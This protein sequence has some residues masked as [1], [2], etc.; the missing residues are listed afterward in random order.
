MPRSLPTRWITLLV[1]CALTA[2]GCVGTTD[3]G[4]QSE[5]GSLAVDLVLAGGIEINQVGWQ[6]TGNGMDMSGD[7][8]VSAPGS[9]ASV[10]VFGLPPGEMDYTV[11][12]TA[13]SSDEAVTCEG[14]APFNVEVGQ[15]TNVM[16]MLNCKKPRTLG[17]VRVNGKFNICTELTKA[18]VS[19]LE[20]SVGNDIS[21]SA[22]AFDEEGD[23]ILYIWTGNG[24]SIADPSAAS[25][26]YTCQEVGDHTVTIMVT[27]NDVYCRM[28]TWTI[29]VTCVE[30]DGGD[31]CEDVM[32]EDDGNECTATECNPA[33]GACETSNVADGTECDGG[34]CSGGVCVEVDLCE[35]V[36]CEDDGNECT[37]EA[38]DPAD[39]VCKTS[40]ADNGTDCSGGDGMCVDGACMISDLCEGVVC[41]DTGN[42]CTVAMCNAATG[43]CDTMNVT[44]GTECNGGDGACSGGVCVDNNLCDGVD[45]SSGNECVQDG[46]CDP[47]DGQCIAGDNQPAGTSCND[48]SGDVCDGNG[49]CVECNSADD[50]PDDGNECTAEACTSNACSTSPVVDG[51]MCDDDM[52]VCD[53]GV[54]V[55]ANLCEG[56]DC[57][58]GNECTQDLCDPGTGACSNPPVADGA[59]CMC[60]ICGAEGLCMMGQCVDPCDDIDCSDGNQ[61]TAD[62]CNVGV[63]S[64]PNVGPG[65]ACSQNGGNVCD[66]AGT[67]VECNID[68]QCDV[69]FSETCVDNT[70]VAPASVTC[71]FANNGSD[72][73]PT[74]SIVGVGCTNNVTSAQSPF[75]FTLVVDVPEAVVGGSAFDASFDGIGVFPEFFLDA[76]QAVVP[77]GVDVAELV[78]IVST[79]QVRSG[80]TGPDVALLADL[81]SL[82]PGPTRI[83]NFPFD[84]VCTADGECLGGVCNPPVNL[85]TLPNSTDCS[86]GGVCDTLGKLATQC[87]PNGFCITGD[88]VIEFEESAPISYTAD[89]SGSVLFGWA[90]QGVP[91]LTLCPAAAPNCTDAWMPDGCY[92]LPTAVFANP[93]APIGIRVNASGLFVPIQCAGGTA[94]GICASGEGCI[95]DADCSTAPCTLTT[96]VICPTPDAGLISC[97]IN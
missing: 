67:C 95:V 6:I 35:G 36:T 33:N 20:T 42:E 58:D 2:L 81:G 87:T 92:D 74:S 27:D 39:G 43:I 76:A 86:A 26:T 91:D 54:C 88:L 18:V 49:A 4:P 45:C 57:S 89:A 10:E 46:T 13:T 71:N 52:G 34:T 48:D 12:L 69:E 8:D 80:A 22:Q 31:L 73:T 68:A 14:S 82:D 38:C 60:P 93:T 30:G 61:C 83:C 59:M 40:N 47:L 66:G 51:T 15:T 1:F 23:D 44:D 53:Q 16:V 19:P 78:D 96:D 50:C 21:L 97:P 62:L 11:A 56:V 84:Q 25:T 9:T 70:C 5:T 75:P 79:V 41:D 72:V 37:T 64:N 3:T 90:D 55:P 24:G 65:G 32:C 17:G 63:C 85:A 7:I 29:P 28:A 77:G 94:G